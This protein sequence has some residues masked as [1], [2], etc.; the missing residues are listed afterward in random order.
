MTAI[1]YTNTCGCGKPLHYREDA[2][3]DFVLGCIEDLGPMSNVTVSG[4]GSFKIPR[5]YIA[6]HGP[7]RGSEWPALIEQYGWP[8]S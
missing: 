5:H 8:Q 7:T 1:D 4:L 3:R 2:I 6:L